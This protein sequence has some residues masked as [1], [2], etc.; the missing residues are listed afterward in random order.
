MTPDPPVRPLLDILICSVY[1]RHEQLAGLLL[2]LGPQLD[3]AAGAARVTVA[4]DDCELP[5]GAKRSALVACS[6]AD[7]VCFVDDDD[8]VSDDYVAMLLSALAH[9]PD[10]VGFEVAVLLDG[11]A[12]K[13]CYHS[14]RYTGWSE[15]TDGYYRD[16]SHLNP[17]RR[18]IAL[19]GLPFL[20]GFG[21]DQA[22]ADKVRQTGLATRERYVDRVLYTY[23]HS[24][25]G[26]LFTGGPQ[27]LGRP[28][29]LQDR[30][31]VSWYRQPT[32][33]APR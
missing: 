31:Y 33:P 25:T 1:A 7:Y 24:S 22:W 6:T 2:V 23:R 17:I 18:E 26:S 4:V 13:R 5:V 9:D 12:S 21:E 15:D 16:L 28:V 32:E 8:M 14:L 29:R 30:M 27:R 10:Y 20:D 19:Q 3:A 11:V